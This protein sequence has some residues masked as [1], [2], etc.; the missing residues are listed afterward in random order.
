M[1][2]STS[3]GATSTPFTLTLSVR[4]MP[5]A[6]IVLSLSM[7]SAPSAYLKVAFR[8]S[9]QRGI[10]QH[11]LVLDVD[12]LDRTD[13]LRER[14]RLR[15]AE[16]LGGVPGAV[17]PDDRRVEAL[18]DGG[19]DAE[20][21]REGEP[22]DLEVAAV[23]DV[24]LVDLVEVVLRGVGGED[25]GQAGVHAHPD[26]RQPPA[27]LP[28]GGQRE[29]LVAEL[30][31]RLAE[32]SLGMRLRQADGHVH[33]VRI[34][35]ERAAE[36]GHHELRV[37]RVHDQVRPMRA[38][39]LGDGRGV[40]GVD[41]HAGEAWRAAERVG[42][43][44]GAGFVVVGEDHRLAPVALRG[45]AGDGLSHRADADEQDS[46]ETPG[47]RVPIGARVCATG[48]RVPIACRFRGLNRAGLRARWPWPDDT[49]DSARDQR[50][51][52]DGRRGPEL[53]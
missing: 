13:A 53:I 39:E 20:H 6:W 7:K 21:R 1:A 50:Q 15:R 25:I 29:L 44:A 51:Q 4:S 49:S 48:S 37:D 26:Q 22:G 18:L 34:G 19:P 23:A 24:D 46:H 45:E 17:L 36:D 38:G 41:L 10:E 42:Q 28:L 9:S 52:S 16:R 27:R 47:V 3:R 11:L 40:A 8:V 32:G 33:V 14:E 43:R 12:A 31:A 2:A 35:V 5:S 30:H